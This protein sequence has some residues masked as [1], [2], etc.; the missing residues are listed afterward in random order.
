MKIATGRK[1]T[2]LRSEN[3]ENTESERVSKFISKMRP[4]QSAD[5]RHQRQLPP[6]RRGEGDSH[7]TLHPRLQRPPGEGYSRCGCMYTLLQNK[8]MW[9]NTNTNQLTEHSSRYINSNQY[10]LPF[11]WDSLRYVLPRR[12]HRQHYA[13]RRCPETMS[14]AL[15]QEDLHSSFKCRNTHARRLKTWQTNERV[16]ILKKPT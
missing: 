16:G 3:A 11:K 4:V 8:M 15:L 13:P 10:F 7:S 12:V 9:K 5:V 6:P 1:F 2:I 14:V